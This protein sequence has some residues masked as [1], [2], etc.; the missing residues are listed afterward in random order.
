MSAAISSSR[1]V[2][3]LDWAWAIIVDGEN[4]QGLKA[5]K[6]KIEGLEVL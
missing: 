1:L 4:W 2:A 5:D 3:S 6:V